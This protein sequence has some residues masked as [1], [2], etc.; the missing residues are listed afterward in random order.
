[1]E[2]LRLWFKAFWQHPGNR[3]GVLD[4]YVELGRN[5]LLMADIAL[6][7]GV[8]ALDY[9]P[10]RTARDDAIAEGRRQ[11]ALELFKAAKLDP[12]DLYSLMEERRPPPQEQTGGR[13]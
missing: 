4:G 10:A 6:R 8:F 7:G 5:R 1:M 9:N 3:R 2:K 13:R 11:L 12:S